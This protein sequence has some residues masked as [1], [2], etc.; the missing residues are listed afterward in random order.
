M[1]LFQ[2]SSNQLT[3]RAVLISIKPKY[4]DLILAGT[5]TV[6]LRR[7]W[8]S[9]HI[10]VMVIYS[11]APIQ[12]LVGIVH[13]AKVHHSDLEELWKVADACGGGVTYEE[14]AEYFTGK[15]KA[16]GIMLKNVKIAKSGVDPKEIFPNFV[17]PQSFQYL[18]PA[19]YFKIV[20]KL[21]PED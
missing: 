12:K 14:L 13:I 1:D 3:G 9:E 10:G 15:K 18:D 7:S 17:P 4:A 21:F 11:S 8:P 16:Y 2:E 5:K 6:E 19:D 20:K